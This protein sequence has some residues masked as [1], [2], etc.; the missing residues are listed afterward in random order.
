M[1][2]YPRNSPEA[3]ARI[4][5]L[6]L[7]ADGHVGRDELDALQWQRL[8]PALGEQPARWHAVLQHL[9]EDMLLASDS[10]WGQRTAVDGA[11]MRALLAEVDDE[12]LRRQVLKL[13]LDAVEADGVVTD[14]EL[15]LLEQVIAAW[16]HPARL[17]A[18]TGTGA[19]VHEAV[20]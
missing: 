20:A 4:V 5:A 3:A 11:T 19:R 12:A 16:G 8:H 9:C 17:V 10:P 1:R 13:C 18:P 15:G 6:A 7:L 14:D 2:S